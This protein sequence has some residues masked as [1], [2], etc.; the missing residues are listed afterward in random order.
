MDV[1]LLPLSGGLHER[2]RPARGSRTRHD[3]LTLPRP[4]RVKTASL[5]VESLPRAALNGYRVDVSEVWIVYDDDSPSL[6]LYGVFE[7]ETEAHSYADEVA[8]LTP[9]GAKVQQFS[10]PYRV[11]DRG[12]VLSI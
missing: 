2:E 1:Y 8:H 10:V 4:T 6:T 9:L 5:G 3:C 11:T 12:T 7:R